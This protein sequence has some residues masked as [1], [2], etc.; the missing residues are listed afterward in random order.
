MAT[1][2]PPSAP[3]PNPHRNDTI[4]AVVIGIV[5]VLG[6]MI[7]FGVFV[8]RNI[9]THTVITENQG[10]GQDSVQIH[11]PFGDLNASGHGQNGR[12]DIRS[13][14]GNLK[15]NGSPD[16][17]ALG[18]E[19]Y[20][21]ARL[22]TSRADSPF[23]QG[24]YGANVGDNATGAQVEINSGDRQV[25]VNVAEFVTP[26][27]A[28]QVLDFY[29]RALARYGSVQRKLENDGAISLRYRPDHDNLREAVVKP[30]GDGTHFVLVHVASGSAAK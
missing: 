16:P 30:A 14:F 1:P 21:G 8:V 24:D 23:H 27:S 22:V 9:V 26:D 13:P 5:L 18:M 17:A 28:Q 2:Y 12:V 15:V 11:S 29:N 25:S 20:P 10:P 6:V 7:F 19:I 3:P 4:L